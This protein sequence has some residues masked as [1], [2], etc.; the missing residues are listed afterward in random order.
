MEASSKLSL[1]PPGQ[2]LSQRR[3]SRS[4][5]RVYSCEE[6]ARGQFLRSK[7]RKRRRSETSE[8]NLELTCT[9]L[10]NSLPKYSEFSQ[11]K[12]VNAD[13]TIISLAMSHMVL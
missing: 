10:P 5:V 3:S 9:T 4:D 1:T 7:V 8:R 11:T 2:S 13:P 12:L 6:K